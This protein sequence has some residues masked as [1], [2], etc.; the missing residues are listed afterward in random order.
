MQRTPMLHATQTVSRSLDDLAVSIGR[1]IFS[2]AKRAGAGGWRWVEDRLLNA[3]L[4]DSAVKGSLFQF[5]DVL[6]ALGSD[7][8]VAELPRTITQN[9]LRQGFA[10]QSATGVEAPA[11]E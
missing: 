3:G 1:Q 8:A 2:A 9:T 10:A 6:P 5:V 7:A 4:R 11:G